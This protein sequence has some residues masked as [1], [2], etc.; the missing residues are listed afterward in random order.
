MD[1]TLLLEGTYPFVRGGVSSWVHQIVSGLGEYRFGLVFLGG[2][3]E[4]YQGIQ[5]KIPDN[6]AY[7]K[8]HYL[9]DFAPRRKPRRR[10]GNRR[11]F[12]HAE[13]LHDV[14]R[15]PGPQD[16]AELVR[17]VMSDLGQRGGIPMEDFLH[18]E[19][20]WDQVARAYQKFCTDPSF[21]D[22]F[23]TVRNMHAPLFP[24]ADMARTLPPTRMVHSVSTGYAGLL[25]A[26]IH[27]TRDIPFVLTEHGIYTKERKIDL[28][29]ATWIKEPD[30]TMGGSL[31]DDV[32]YI[33][34]LWIRFFEQLG[35]LAYDAA[36]PIVSLYEGNRQ[37]QIDDGAPA[38]RT[39]VIPN[40]IDMVRYEAALA[41]READPPPVAALVGRVVPIKDVKTFIRSMRTVCD[42]LPDAQGW[43][44]GPEDEAPEY[45]QECRSLVQNLGLE[46]R[47]RFRGFQKIPEIMDQ[48]GVL[49]LSSISEA[50]PLV[51][52]EGFAG[53]V[54]TVATDVGACRELI[55]GA[56]EADRALG[57]AGAITPIADPQATGGAIIALLSNGERWRAAQAAGLERAR[58]YYREELMY[59]AYRDI[60]A[61]AMDAE[62]ATAAVPATTPAAQER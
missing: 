51:I 49:V 4:D 48:I 8:T 34:R 50:L 40:G 44:I 36:T 58:R 20:A 2:R 56:A 33:R 57:S 23:W 53:G 31:T 60:Y 1:V 9:M 6:V 45:V 62:P 24:L 17:Q 35:R 18:S 11:A 15:D 16:S 12:E 27:Q 14:F 38:E 37:R 52:L 13:A 26:M 43:I 41:R 7:L 30:H 61:T 5:Y 28:A 29:Q 59:S 21:V 54:P 19:A 10:K 39:R 25:A 3:K 55:E 22:Y 32:S 47:V 46:G 42:R